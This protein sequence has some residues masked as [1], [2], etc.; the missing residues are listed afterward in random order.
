[1]SDLFAGL[2]PKT[3]EKEE[4]K[5]EKKAEVKKETKEN[6]KTEEKKETKTDKKYKFP[7]GIY[8]DYQLTD[9][10]HVFEEGKEYTEAEITKMM[11]EHRFYSFAGKVTYDYV[12]ADNVLVPTFQQHKK[13]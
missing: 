11:L 2:K 13:G 4:P 12:E 8:I 7:F 9:I 5:K 3:I 6:K 10:S 1:M